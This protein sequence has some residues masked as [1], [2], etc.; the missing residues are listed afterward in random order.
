MLADIV[1]FP[2]PGMAEVN[3]AGRYSC[4]RR[5][6]PIEAARNRNDSAVADIG[7]AVT[8]SAEVIRSA[9]KRGTSPSKGA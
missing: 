5:V 7:F 2:L 4:G 9:W 3:T 1:V 6:A 8:G